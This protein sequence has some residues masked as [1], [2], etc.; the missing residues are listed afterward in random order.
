[1]EVLQALV[2]GVHLFAAVI[3]VGGSFFM[4]MVVMPASHLVTEDESER[5]QMVGKIAKAFG[6]ITVPTIAILLLTGVYN[7]TW[8]LPSPSALFDTDRGLVLLAKIV[9]VFVLLVLIFVHNVYYGKRIVRLAREKRLEELKSLRRRSRV[10]SFT[11][12]GLMVLI[13]ALAV[14]LQVPL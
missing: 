2:L 4:W 10:V 6:R 11:N 8:Y 7:A 3:F 14:L 5:T 1:M 9:A 13:L 12:L